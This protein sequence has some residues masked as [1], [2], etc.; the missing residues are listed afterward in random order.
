MWDAP[1]TQSTYWFGPNG[2]RDRVSGIKLAYTE[3][4]HGSG[5]AVGCAC[6]RLYMKAARLSNRPARLDTAKLK[7]TA[8]ETHRLDLRNRLRARNLMETPP[9]TRVLIFICPLL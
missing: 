6:L 5:Y 7:I 3:S 4:E 9:Q 8:L 1:E 2:L